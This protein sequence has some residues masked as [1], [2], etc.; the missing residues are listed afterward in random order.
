MEV[1]THSWSHPA[2]WLQSPKRCRDE[3]LSIRLFLEQ[4]VQHPVISFA[5]PFNYRPAYDLAGDYVLRAQSDAQYLSC[6][7]TESGLLRLDDLGNP[8]AM[9]TNGHFLMPREKIEQ[10][11]KSASNT[12]LGVFYIWGHSYEMTKEAEWDAFEN[13]LKVYGKRSEAWYA[14]QGDLMVWQWMR[15]QVR[16]HATGSANHLRIT[17]ERPVL[18]PWWAARVPVAL[19]FSGA[20][21]SATLNNQNLE[22]IANQVQIPWQ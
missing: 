22:I 1:G 8:L 21:Q 3:S 19:K 18:H 12:P 14:A 2:Y 4:R 13:L 10:A 20:I 15:S 9:S 6:R 16:V 7:S 17:L 5:Y 11:W